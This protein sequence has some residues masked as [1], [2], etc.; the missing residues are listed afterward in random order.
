MTGGGRITSSVIGFVARLLERGGGYSS[1]CSDSSFLAS[2]FL[3]PFLFLVEVRFPA[4]DEFGLEWREDVPRD[5]LVEEGA[6]IP[7]PDFSSLDSMGPLTGV[8]GESE[9]LRRFKSCFGSSE[10]S[11]VP[12][13]LLLELVPR[14]E[15]PESLS[16]LLSSKTF[17]RIASSYSASREFM[18]VRRL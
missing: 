12:R 16:F 18:V 7:F 9:V 8:S 1:E 10:P 3:S 5:F 14:V 2:L 4:A 11:L 17:F 15:L 6:V 13:F